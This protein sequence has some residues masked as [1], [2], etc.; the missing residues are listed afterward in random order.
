M[1]RIGINGFGRIGRAI[2]KISRMAKN[3]K[4]VVVNDIDPDYK[5]LGYLLKY[6]SIYGRYHTKVD[7][8]K[9]G[10]LVNGDQVDFYSQEKITSVPWKKYGID[11]VIDASGVENNVL[12]SHELVKYDIEKVIITHATKHVNFSM[13]LGVN[14][15]KYDKSNHHVVSTS[16]CDANAI[17]PVLKIVEDNLGIESGFIT[18][19]HPWLSYQNLLDG[20]VSSISN[21]GHFWD[22]YSLGRASHVNLIPKETTAL[23]ATFQ[24]LPELKDKLGSISFRVP[25]MV[26]SAS[27]MVLNIKENISRP[28]LIKLFQN[29]IGKRHNIAMNNEHLVSIDF[30]GTNNSAIVDERYIKV[31]NGKTCK[32]VLWYDNEWGYSSRVM[33]VAKFL[34]KNRRKNK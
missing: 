21:P 22:D 2:Y 10:L 14:D 6:D 9:N 16:I 18:T 19:L 28:E 25:T 17:A 29:H 8:N 15:D 20:T 1:I 33:E 13:I 24:V 3:I 30:K 4:V 26:V 7:I 27:D 11:I 32:I 5:N 34:L 31:I 23:A 12:L